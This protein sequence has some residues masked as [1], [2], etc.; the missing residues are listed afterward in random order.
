MRNASSFRQQAREALSGNWPTAIITTLVAGL[1]GGSL[2]VQQTGMNIVTTSQQTMQNQDIQYN[3]PDGGYGTNVLLGAAVFS[4]SL[5]LIISLIQFLVGGFVSLGLIQF[6]MN[7]I[8]KKP[9]D[10]MDIFSK[11]DMFVKAL[12][13]RLRLTVFTFLWT[14]L[15]II[16]GI[17]KSYSYSMS[18]FIMTEN[19]EISSKEAMEVS[20]KMMSGNKWRLFCLQLSFIG[21]YILGAMACGIGIF[22]VQPYVNAAIA[23][24][25]DDVSRN[26]IEME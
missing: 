21:W 25:Y 3:L 12:F 8:D 5:I 13:L 15:F 6:N 14:L 11:S 4:G 24:F 1:L 16:P 10:F 18:G 9:V 2:F 26:P 19:P 23:G 20:M 22:F 7:L 17:I